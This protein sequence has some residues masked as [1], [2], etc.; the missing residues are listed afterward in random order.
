M[1]EFVTLFEFANTKTVTLYSRDFHLTGC[2]RFTEEFFQ[3]KGV[4]PGRHQVSAPSVSR[5]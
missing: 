2:N 4:R 3:V 1:Q 5:V